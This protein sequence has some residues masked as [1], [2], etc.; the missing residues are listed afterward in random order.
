MKRVS[1]IRE[2]GVV[3]IQQP[4]KGPFSI[5]CIDNPQSE[6]AYRPVP[7]TRCTL[8]PQPKSRSEMGDLDQAIAC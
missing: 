3:V 8:K 7:N 6:S 5:I 4:T 1:I 2:G